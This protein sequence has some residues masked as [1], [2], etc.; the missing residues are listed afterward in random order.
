MNDEEDRCHMDF[1]YKVIKLNKKKFIQ[2]EDN[3]FRKWVFEDKLNIFHIEYDPSRRDAFV[4]KVLCKPENKRCKPFIYNPLRA[5][6]ES[7]AIVGK[8][9]DT[10]VEI[11]LVF[12]G[13]T[14]GT[15]ICTRTVSYMLKVLLLEAKKLEKYPY[16][17]MVH[18]KTPSPCAAGNCYKHAFQNNDF[19]PDPNEIKAFI[20]K[21]K[22]KQ[23]G[24]FD[25]TFKN[26]LNVSQLRIQRRLL[27][28]EIKREHLSKRK[29]TLEKRFKKI[30]TIWREAWVRPKN[31]QPTLKF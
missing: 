8:W 1:N 29:E 24:K 27:L 18:I 5:L 20:A 21:T 11:E 17:G 7:K 30:K 13:D 4:T 25:F 9:N 3:G 22:E 19:R 26:F 10:T 12:L 14:A 16:V 15:G 6:R 28:K 23:N 2:E 31:V